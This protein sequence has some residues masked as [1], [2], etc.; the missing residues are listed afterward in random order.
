MGPLDTRMRIYFLHD[1][2]LFYSFIHSMVIEISM[3][4]QLFIFGEVRKHYGI[5]SV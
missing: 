3:K 1:Y 2:T 4:D 5:L